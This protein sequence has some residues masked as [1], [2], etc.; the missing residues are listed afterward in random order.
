MCTYFEILL[1]TY[2]TD[3]YPVKLSNVKIKVSPRQL[4]MT[5]SKITR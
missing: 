1:E 3:L 2:F 4:T 5:Y